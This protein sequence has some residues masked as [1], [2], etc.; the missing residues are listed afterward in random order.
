[1]SECAVLAGV[2]MSHDDSHRTWSQWAAYSEGAQ[3]ANIANI[4]IATIQ[5]LGTLRQAAVHGMAFY[6]QGT[7]LYNAQPPTMATRSINKSGKTWPVI[8]GTGGRVQSAPFLWF[9]C[10]DQGPCL[11]GRAHGILCCH[12]N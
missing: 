12:A 5:G 6:C 3:V 11:V 9:I 4:A 8:S 7:S 2:Q 1:M 10:S